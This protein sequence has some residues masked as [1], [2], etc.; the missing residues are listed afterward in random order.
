MLKN[1]GSKYFISVNKIQGAPFLEITNKFDFDGNDYF[2]LYNSRRIAESILNFINKT[3]AIRQCNL[4][5]YI[6]G[7][8][9]F[10][11]DI[12]RCT[13]PCIGLE[14]NI[15]KHNLEINEVYKFLFGENQ[16]ALNRLLNKMKYYSSLQE[17]EK[18]AEIKQLVDYLLNE[19]SKTSLLSE[20]INK[21]KVLIEILSKHKNDFL[22]LL[23]GRVFIKNY[24]FDCKN[25]FEQ[26]L[27]DYFNNTIFTNSLPNE[28]DFEKLKVT[29]NWLIKNRNRVKLYYLRNYSSK[30]DL[31]KSIDSFKIQFSEDY[32]KSQP[33]YD[34]NI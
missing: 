11:F 33:Q 15:S 27:D 34:F 13:A 25:Y 30:E 8:S 2:G 6:K 5:Q 1:Y 3:F 29:L 20:P 26:A 23:E 4:K 18:A 10:L 31:F 16:N 19:I 12:Q 17:Y 14:Y 28:E 9:C 32:L 22:L 7:K 21:A 24:I